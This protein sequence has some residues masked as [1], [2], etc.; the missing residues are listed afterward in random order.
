MLRACA[1][2]VCLCAVCVRAQVE[3]LALVLRA[4][5]AELYGLTIQ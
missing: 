4:A 2:A 1:P 3:D 5:V